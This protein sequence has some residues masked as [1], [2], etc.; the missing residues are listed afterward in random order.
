MNQNEVG[1]YIED[2]PEKRIKKNDMVKRIIVEDL[3]D[4]NSNFIQQ[5]LEGQKRNRIWLF[6]I[7]Y[8]DLFKNNDLYYTIAEQQVSKFT[9]PVYG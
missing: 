2:R 8:E 5:S 7:E 9:K 3:E 6:A 4:V 1:E